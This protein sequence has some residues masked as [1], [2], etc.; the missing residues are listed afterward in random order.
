MYAYLFL[1]Y[2]LKISINLKKL[3][4]AMTTIK[5]VGVAK[6]KTKV[7]KKTHVELFKWTR[8]VS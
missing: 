6:R 3:V 8:K 2:P 1:I 5:L 7:A 4:N